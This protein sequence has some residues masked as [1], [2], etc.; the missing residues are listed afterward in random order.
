MNAVLEVKDIGI[1][2]GGVRAVDEVSFDIRPG[3]IFSI[4]GPNAAGKTTMFN[5]IPA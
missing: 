5:L 2:F 1:D 3:Q 4:I